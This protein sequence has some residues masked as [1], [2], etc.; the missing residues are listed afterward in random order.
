MSGSGTLSR[1]VFT[2]VAPGAFDV[3]IG[4][5]A[6][7]TDI[8]GELLARTLAA[9]LSLTVCGST[10]ISGKVTM[11][12]R[13]GNNVNTGTVTLTDVGGGGGFPPVSTTFSAL[14]GAFS[15]TNVPVMPLGS[16]YQM[17]AAHSL[18]LTNR[19]DG[20]ADVRRPTDR[21]EYTALGR[22]RQQQRQGGNR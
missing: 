9:P 2:G 7:L 6:V 16:S 14:D 19:Q 17:D 5:D 4:S 12:G 21:A 20:R 1:I 8:D 18:Y 10:T 3:T 22:R 15:F 13:S 11:Q